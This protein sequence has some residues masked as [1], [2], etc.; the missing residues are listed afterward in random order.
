MPLPLD[1]ECP[2]QEASTRE[3]PMSQE[4]VESAAALAWEVMT[5]QDYVR[6]S[7][8]Y[9]RERYL[10]ELSRSGWN[11]S[12]LGALFGLTKQRVQQLLKQMGHEKGQRR[13]PGIK[14]L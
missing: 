1:K 14:G 11:H 2:L 7:S 8:N 12:Q 3:V 5:Y 4:Q 6:S 9:A 13:R 10:Q